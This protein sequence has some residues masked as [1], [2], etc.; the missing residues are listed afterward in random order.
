VTRASGQRSLPSVATAENEVPVYLPS[1]AEHIFGVLTTPT[2]PASGTA[3]L[4]L[5]AGEQNLSC[6]RNRLWARLA[7]E[8]AGLGHHSLRLDFHGSGDSSG[9]LAD[10]DVFGQAQTDVRSAVDWLHE[11]YAQRIVL[12]ATCW[13]ALVGLVTAAGSDKVVRLGLVS[14]PL[15]VLQTGGS[16]DQR[17]LRRQENL[18]AAV[19]AAARIQVVQLLISRP[20][21]RRWALARLGRRVLRRP[22]TGASS[23]AA[24]FQP[25]SSFGHEMFATLA[26]REV[27][28]H[29]LFGEHDRTWLG[30]QEQGGLPDVGPAAAVLDVSVTP[31]SVHG[32]GTLLAQDVVRQHVLDWVSRA[33]L[34]GDPGDDRPQPAP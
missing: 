16:P 14:P 18:W 21:Y 30:L 2:G 1:G 12:V 4:F 15:R 20:D 5:H 13:G 29:V 3:V 34:S 27:S 19:R 17:G 25:A 7:R 22:A 23:P 32:L 24:T 28:V 10:R 9:V 26:S 8:L 11:N 6:H 33:V 31:V